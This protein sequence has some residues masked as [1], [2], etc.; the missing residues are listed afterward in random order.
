MAARK[1]YVLKW[2]GS[3][4]AGNPY[5]TKRDAERAAARLVREAKAHG[6]FYGHYSVALM[7]AEDAATLERRKA[8]LR[9]AQA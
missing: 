7:T 2:C 6:G 8:P 3:L 9:K 4:C 1:A 5:P